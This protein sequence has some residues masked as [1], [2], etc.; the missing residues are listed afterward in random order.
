MR[1][2]SIVADSMRESGRDYFVRF[3]HRS[4]PGAVADV[5]VCSCDLDGGEV[6]VMA[7]PSWIIYD[8]PAQP[9]DADSWRAVPADD[10][11]W[12]L[13]APYESIG[14]ADQAAKAIAEAL[15]R[16]DETALEPLGED[17][18]ADLFAWDGQ[19]FDPA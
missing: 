3:R 10:D 1:E 19:E 7:S 2:S 14:Q 11:R 17:V 6:G 4:V 15:M 18:L 13:P 12:C 16:G 8:N 5:L 9:L